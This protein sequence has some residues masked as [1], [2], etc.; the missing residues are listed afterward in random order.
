[1]VIVKKLEAVAK[2]PDITSVTVIL[3]NDPDFNACASQPIATDS[4]T[5]VVNIGCLKELK[6]VDELA[7]VLGHEWS[8]ILLGHTRYNGVYFES[9]INSEMYADL[10]GQ[11]IARLAGYDPGYGYDLWT[12]VAEKF[13]NIGGIDHPYC[14]DRAAYLNI[15]KSYKHQIYEDLF[16]IGKYVNQIASKLNNGR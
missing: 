16:S 9:A 14:L 7:L 4:A 5:I 11:Q 12:H 3:C 2:P 15:P 6:N 10:L 13:G 8:H 1:M